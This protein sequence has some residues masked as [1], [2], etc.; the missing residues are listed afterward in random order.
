MAGSPRDIALNG[1]PID[2]P[3][4]KCC[5][6]AIMLDKN[7]PLLPSHQLL[8]DVFALSI[9]VRDPLPDRLNWKAL[10]RRRNATRNHR[11]GADVVQSLRLIAVTEVQHIDR[12]DHVGITQRVVGVDKVNL[13]GSM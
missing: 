3:K 9:A 8:R 11:V 12:P 7:E 1:S 13:G 6:L 5:I 4:Q 10:I 2:S